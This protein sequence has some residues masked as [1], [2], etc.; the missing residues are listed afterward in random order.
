[1]DD[2]EF[3]SPSSDTPLVARGYGGI[4]NK[5]NRHAT[6]VVRGRVTIFPLLAGKIERNMENKVW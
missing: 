3:Q 2:D 5:R 4:L 6:K 1:M